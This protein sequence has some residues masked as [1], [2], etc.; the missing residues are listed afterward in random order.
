MDLASSRYF[1]INTSAPPNVLCCVSI[2]LILQMKTLRLTVSVRMD[3]ARQYAY[4]L[5]ST[6]TLHSRF[7]LDS[8]FNV[9]KIPWSHVLLSLA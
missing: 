3:K 4:C 9:L 8:D 5:Q 7:L 6:Y 1:T 2:L